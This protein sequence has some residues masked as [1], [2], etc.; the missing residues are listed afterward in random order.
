MELVGKRVVVYGGGK[1]GLSAYH[2]AVERGARAIIYDDDETVRHSTSSIGVFK[3]ADIIVLSPGVDKNKELLL[4]AKL[5]GKTVVSELELASSCC[6][7]EQ[8]A[9]TGTNGKTTTTLLVDHIFKCAFKKSYPLGNVGIAFSSVADRL[10][11][12][13]LAI[14]E[15]SSFQLEGCVRFAPDIA[16]LLNIKPD[17]LERHGSFEKYVLAKSAIIKN[18]SESDYVVYNADDDAICALLP[19]MVATKV[20]FGLKEPHLRGA[21]ISSGFVC[22]KG[23]P[24]ISVADIPFEGDELQNVLAA[25]C[26]CALHGVSEYTIAKAISTFSRPEHRRQFVE[27]IDGIS[28]FDDSKATNVSACKSAISTLNGDAVLILGGAKRKENFD[29]LFSDLSHN[30]KRIVVCGENFADVLASAKKFEFENIAVCDDLKQ[31]VEFA[32]D[33]AKYNECTTVM[34]SPASKSFDAF[35]SYEERG[36]FFQACVLD[37]SKKSATQK[38]NKK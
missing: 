20:P 11:S 36:R 33:V 19:Q 15:A 24:I 21:Y 27:E 32:F 3:D 30:V 18:Q 34:F 28:F 17:H 7:A 29:E 26:V 37:L 31:S 12:T 13:E 4:E 5:E 8:I 2:L 25:V 16:V 10:D 22:F 38:R 6:R 1:S 14:V 9:I 35:S 23:S